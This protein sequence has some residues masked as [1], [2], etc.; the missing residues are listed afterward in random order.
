MAHSKITCEHCTQKF[1]R[2]EMTAHENE[3][4]AARLALLETHIGKIMSE[5]F[6]SKHPDQS[7]FQIL[8]VEQKYHR[9]Q[10]VQISGWLQN[11]EKE[12]GMVN[13]HLHAIRVSRRATRARERARI[14]TFL[15]I[16]NSSAS[17]LQ[18]MLR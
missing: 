14:E 13:R 10:L 7:S 8:E 6:P 5:V 9:E 12:N 2:S 1:K 18:N 4:L 3:H 11:L 15:G 17:S 16:I